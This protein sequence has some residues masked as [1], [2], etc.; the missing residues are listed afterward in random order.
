VLRYL[1]NDA[2]TFV[3]MPGGVPGGIPGGQASTGKSS[4][5]VRAGGHVRQ[6]KAIAQTHPEYPALA[7]EAHIQGDLKIDA[8]LD[9]QGNIIDMKIHLWTSA[10]VS[11]GAR[12]LEKM[13]VR[14]YL[15]E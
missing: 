12:R 2:D 5:P 11:G 9:E 15:F 10:S 3:G 8:I 4:A 6:P 7:R 1:E 14:A 13:E